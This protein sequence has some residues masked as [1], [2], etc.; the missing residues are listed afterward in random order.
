MK[1]AMG[2]LPLSEFEQ[3]VLLAVVRLEDEAYGVTVH[4][5]IES[6][7]G[8]SASVTATYA[9]LER[10]EQRGLATSR[11]GEATPVRGGRAKKHFQITPQGALALREA[12]ADME[13]MWKGLDA[14]PDLEV[15]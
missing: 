9:A 11:V 5:E 4:R 15:P 3:M 13:R 2:E 7:T 14:H 6:R 1:A 10:M 12:R 8:R